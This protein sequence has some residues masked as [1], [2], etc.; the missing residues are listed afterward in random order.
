MMEADLIASG[1]DWVVLRDGPYADNFAKRVAEAARQDGIFRMAAGEARLPFI[2]RADLSEAA[3]AAVL[4]ERSQVAWR[5]SGAELL[6]CADLCAIFSETLGL[7]VRYRA[8]S[9][10]EQMA[11]LQ[12]QG[13]RADLIER[14][15]AYGRAIREG[16]M[17][18]L[19]DDF[20][21]LVGRAPARVRD[22][23][24]T[25]D[26]NLGGQARQHGIPAS[27]VRTS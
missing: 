26:L 4:S 14:R 27:K 2:G 12:R 23:L 10:E 24:P 3:A 15:I 5:L 22:L 19:T 20:Q 21:T 25:L 16:Y 9:D 6:S 18:A 7:A 8:I 17:T 1:V 13:L 11:D